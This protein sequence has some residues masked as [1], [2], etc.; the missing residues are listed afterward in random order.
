MAVLAAFVAALAGALGLGTDARSLT[1]REKAALLVVSSPPV[2][3]GVTNVFLHRW[4]TDDERPRR[5]LVLVDQE[6][7]GVRAYPGL[8]PASPAASYTSAASA[9]TAGRATGLGL[10]KLG[11]GVDL[12]PVLDSPDGPLGSRHFRRASY[13]VAFARGLASAGVAACAKHFPGLGST[14]ES[15]DSRRPVR[16]IVRASELAGFRAAIEAG[17]PCVMVSHAIYPRFGRAPASIEPEAYRLLREQGF[18]GV[19]ITDELGVLGHARAAEWARRA[20]LAGADLVLFSSATSAA[21]AIDALVPLAR[22][23]LLDPHVARVLRL[24]AVYRR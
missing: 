20:V 2:P 18:T 4:E 7:G 19:A 5:A 3:R 13:G 23:G 1:P 21:R 6:G 8:P 10:R 15:T 16:G 12:A 9:K 17:V 11:V 14:S 22:R 24:Q